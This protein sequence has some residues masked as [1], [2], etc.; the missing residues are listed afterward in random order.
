MFTLELSKFYTRVIEAEFIFVFKV[1]KACPLIPVIARTITCHFCPLC[2][3]HHHCLQS[4]VF[5]DLS[6]F[7][8]HVFESVLTLTTKPLSRTHC[9]V[10]I[11]MDAASLACTVAVPFSPDITA[12]SGHPDLP[13]HRGHRACIF[14]T[15]CVHAYWSSHIKSLVYL[16]ARRFLLISS[17]SRSRQSPLPTSNA[18]R[19][20]K[21]ESCFVFT[22]QARTCARDPP[23]VAVILTIA[24]KVRS[25]KTT[26][27]AGVN[28]VDEDLTPTG[29]LSEDNIF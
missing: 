24:W 27:Q 13:E 15:F 3:R 22:S 20:V 21:R 16:Y 1:L 14:T 2:C 18:E 12:Q 9:I 8:R 10:T 11:L 17:V 28:D 23:G 19:G 26:L 25:T 7:V 4:A 5:V 6:S 29:E